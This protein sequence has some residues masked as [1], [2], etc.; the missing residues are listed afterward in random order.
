ERIDPLEQIKWLERSSQVLSEHPNDFEPDLKKAL[1]LL[2]AYEL[3][4]KCG[5]AVEGLKTYQKYHNGQTPETPRG[6]LYLTR[7]IRVAFLAEELAIARTILRDLES[8]HIVKA[9]PT[10][11][12]MTLLLKTI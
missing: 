7:Y 4:V 1:E 8:H 5:K 11:F 6:A 2:I 9:T 3:A 10:I 12:T